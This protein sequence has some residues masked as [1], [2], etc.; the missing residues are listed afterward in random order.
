MLLVLDLVIGPPISCKGSLDGLVAPSS[1]PL[2]SKGFIL[3]FHLLPTSK[4]DRSVPLMIK[5]SIFWIRKIS[6]SQ[7]QRRFGIL[8]EEKMEYAGQ[9][10]AKRYEFN[11]NGMELIN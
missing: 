9:L 4:K 5:G 6:M 11:F 1:F 7:S 10:H 3:K 8:T 2:S